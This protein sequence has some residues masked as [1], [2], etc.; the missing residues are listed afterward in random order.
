MTKTFIE[1]DADNIQHQIKKIFLDY[2]QGIFHLEITQDNLDEIASRIVSE[3]LGIEDDNAFATL[4]DIK[5][6]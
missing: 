1:I 3:V 6:K 2:A 4:K 5:R